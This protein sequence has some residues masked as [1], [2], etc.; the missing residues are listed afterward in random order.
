MRECLYETRSELEYSDEDQVEDKGPFAAEAV[1]DYA[2]NGLRN[3][4]SQQLDICALI[5]KRH[6]KPILPVSYMLTI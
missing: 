1:G 4:R 2:E 3:K 5:V 6:T